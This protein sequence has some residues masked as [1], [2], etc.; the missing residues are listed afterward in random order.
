M[1]GLGPSEILLI[2]TVLIILAVLVIIAVIVLVAANKYLSGN[3]VKKLEARVDSL[4]RQLGE[5]QKK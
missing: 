2:F 4:E 5:Q 1:L 3:R